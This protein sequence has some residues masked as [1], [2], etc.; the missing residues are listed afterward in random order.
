MTAGTRAVLVTGASG[1]L[2]QA[3]VAELMQREEQLVWRQARRAIEGERTVQADL[4]DPSLTLPQ[5]DD[6][7]HLAGAAHLVPRT[8]L[9]RR[10][11]YETNVDGLSNLL[12]VLESAPPKRFVLAS[13]VAV[14][15][16]QQ[17]CDIGEGQV[18]AAT[19]PYG[20]SKRIAEDVVSEWCDRRSIALTTVRLPLVA[21]RNAPGNFGAMT[22]ALRHRRYLGVGDGLAR[23]SMVLVEDAAQ[24][25]S[26]MC[27]TPG[28]F[29]V[30]DGIHPS[31]REIEAAMAKAIG[32]QVPRR[33][34]LRTARVLAACG[35]AFEAVSG[36]RLPFN[37]ELLQKMTSTL[38]FSDA[39]FRSTFDWRPRSVATAVAD[40]TL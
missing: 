21:G 29:H 2:G 39:H 26:M 7:F 23:R 13:T 40:W 11:F 24:A 27:G 37:R 32:R 31:F 28:V 6:V 17:G 30:N 3:V 35:S 15:G 16:L 12:K 34:T 5:V 36:R 20:E 10:S 19:D 33:L 14:Y 9:Q 38:T 8:E 22:E 1:F 25:F 18:R 4:R